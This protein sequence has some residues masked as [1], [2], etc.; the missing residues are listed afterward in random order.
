MK[1][2]RQA[3]APGQ[4][5]GRGPLTSNGWRVGNSS[6]T[7]FLGLLTDK[8]G[9]FQTQA[10]A[11]AGAMQDDPA[12]NWDI[13]ISRWRMRKASMIL[14]LRMENTQVFR[15]AR[16]PKLA[17]PRCT[18]SK[19]S[20]T[21][22]SA[23]VRSRN[24]RVA[25]RTRSVR[26]SHKTP[27][28]ARMLPAQDGLEPSQQGRRTVQPVDG[29]PGAQQ[30]VLDQILGQMM[31]PTQTIGIA[32]EQRPVGSRQLVEFERVRWQLGQTWITPSAWVLVMGRAG[33]QARGREAKA[34]VMKSMSAGHPY[35]PKPSQPDTITVRRHRRMA[36]V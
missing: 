10:Q 27:E 32:V 19:V 18:A 25:K 22:S 14:R 8:P 3:L 4:G 12:P 20:C 6:W 17:C 35:S 23:R 26:W 30:A 11:H 9:V 29:A 7:G 33:R 5:G 31:M 13:G 16:S 34:S 15:L 24:C 21:T 1:F 28:S 2:E 36:R